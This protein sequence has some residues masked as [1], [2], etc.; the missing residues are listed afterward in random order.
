MNKHYETLGVNSNASESDIKKAYKKLAMKYHPDRGGDASKFKE[1][2]EAYQYLLDPKNTQYRSYTSND[3]WSR[4]EFDD[5][6][7]ETDYRHGTMFHTN[8]RKQSTKKTYIYKISLEDAYTGKV[9]HY[10]NKAVK[11]PAGVRTGNKLY[12]S[13]KFLEIAVLPHD[14]FQRA[15]DDLLVNV[16]ISAIEAML[17]VEVFITHINGSKLKFKIQPGIQP[18]NVVRL[19]GKGMPNPE[20]DKKGDLLIRCNVYVPEILPDAD[21]IKIRSLIEHNRKSIEI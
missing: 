16:S 17:G 19:L 5:F 10:D 6:T 13:G 2:N 15:E 9:I 7:D 12:I 18:G 21:I 20:L 3:K 1:I 11:I 14:K 8:N 4:Y